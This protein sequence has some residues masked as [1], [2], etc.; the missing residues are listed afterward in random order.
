MKFP[1]I[2]Y[3]NQKFKPSPNSAI[4]Y[5]WTG[6]AWDI[7]T[8]I[9][10]NPVS[11]IH[12]I[13]KN[14]IEING[15]TPSGLTNSI[16]NVFYL[17]NSPITGTDEVYLNGLRQTRDLDYTISDNKIEFTWSPYENANI[18]CNYE[19]L[20][21]L[22]IEGESAVLLDD[23]VF[24]KYSLVNSPIIGS[25]RV[26]I[27]GMRAKYG[28]GFDYNINGNIITINYNLDEN[29]RILCDYNY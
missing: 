21:D 11:D 17:A 8:D 2:P 16:N 1:K 10:G 26:Y 3:L 29:S 7:Y 5:I 19:I 13:K 15:E 4:S 24:T 20:S 9:I 25:E 6:Y 14:S 18:L 28:D 12:I 23:G 22:R 27:N